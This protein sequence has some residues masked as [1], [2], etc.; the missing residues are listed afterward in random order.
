MAV[1]DNAWGL[2]LFVPY[3]SDDH[4][5][6]FMREKIGSN[7]TSWK[8]ANAYDISE[9]SQDFV[10]T[11]RNGTVMFQS[12]REVSTD[13]VNVFFHEYCGS[14]YLPQNYQVYCPVIYT[15]DGTMGYMKIVED[16][17]SFYN[18]DGTQIES[19]K[20]VAFTAMY[21]SRNDAID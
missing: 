9:V 17:V 14:I 19:A 5:R 20:V 18:L 2:Q 1:H 21:L 12:R 16:V 11:K 3:S 7:W 4:A 13:A 15:V 8:R 6:L 10:L